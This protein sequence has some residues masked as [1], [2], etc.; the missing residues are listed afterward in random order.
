MTLKSCLVLFSIKPM[1]DNA[2]K[3]TK[4][5]AKRISGGRIRERAGFSH[6]AERLRDTAK[7]FPRT[8][9]GLR[10]IAKWF[11]HTAEGL[12][13]GARTFRTLRKRFAT[14]REPSE[15]FGNASQRCEDLQNSSETLRNGART[16]RTLR[17]RFATAR[18]ASELFGNASR[19]REM[20]PA[21]RGRAFLLNSL[22]PSGISPFKRGRKIEKQTIPAPPSEGGAPRRGEGVR[23]SDAAPLPMESFRKRGPKI[24]RDTYIRE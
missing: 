8:A 24:S 20:V 1:N 12:R 3:L 16:F 13:D 21:H 9:E 2:Y 19:H 7:W 10:G 4:K 22:C 14:T 23:N 6:T 18:G 11:P 15:L 5:T 17:K